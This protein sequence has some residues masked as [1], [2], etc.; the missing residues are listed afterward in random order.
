[1]WSTSIDNRV[2]SMVWRNGR[3]TAPEVVFDA[4]PHSFIHNGGRLLFDGRDILFASTGDADNRDLAQDPGSRA[5]KILRMTPSG[6]VPGGNPDPGS[7]V[8]SLGH[9]NVQGLSLDESGR[10]WASEFGASDV[11]ELNRIVRGGNYGWPVYEGRGG[12]ADGY[13]DPAATWSP[14]S[15]ASPSGMAI[16]G[17]SAWIAGLRGETLW[18]VPLT[19]N[20]AG[21]PIAWFT[22]EFG[23][24]RDVVAAPGGSLWIVTNNTDGRGSPRD[25]DDR[26]LRVRLS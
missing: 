14:T 10:L 22:G 3:L 19:G 7:A 12:S 24:L 26:I 16:V 9:R 23:R 6:A 20:R 11:D 5:G 17:R 18:Q 15:T 21:E 1:M 25:G 13:F 4:I 2:G 8:W